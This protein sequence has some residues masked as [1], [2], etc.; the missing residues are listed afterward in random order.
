MNKSI[1]LSKYDVSLQSNQ[2]ANIMTTVKNQF[3]EVVTKWESTKH[4]DNSNFQ[5]LVFW[6]VWEKP[7]GRVLVGYNLGSGSKTKFMY[8]ITKAEAIEKYN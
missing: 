8:N 4:P 2:K 3:G 7:D 1:V 5:Q 6:T